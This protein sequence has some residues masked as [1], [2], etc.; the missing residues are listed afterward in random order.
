MK[1]DTLGGYPSVSAYV[2]AKLNRLETMERDF[3]S[4]FELMFSES[5]NVLYERSTGYRIVSTSYGEAR[6]AVLRCVPKLE[7]ALKG[8]PKGQCVGLA[9]ANGVEWIEVFWAILAAGYCPLLINTRLDD[10]TLEEVLERIGA[11]AVITDDRQFSVRLIKPEEILGEGVAGEPAK[12]FGTQIF[13]MSSGTSSRVKLCAYTAEQFLSLIRDSLDIIKKCRPIQTHYEGSL[14]LLAFLPFYHVFGLVAMYVWFGFFSRTFV[15]LQDLSPQTILGTI[16]RHKVT[17]VFAVPLFWET[18]YKECIRTIKERGN[19]TFA[20]FEKGLEIYRK[21]SGF[22]LLCG[23]FSKKAFREVRE[24]LFGESISFM[25][26]GGSEIKD[27][28]LEFFNAIG[29]PLAN[30]YGMTEIGI[31]SV[32]LSPKASVRTQ[33]FVGEP[34]SSVEYS[35]SEDGELLVRGPGLAS[36]VLDGEKKKENAG[37]WFC[38]GDLAENVNGHYRILGRKD[39]LI[40]ASSGE[41]LN[42]VL[43][44][45]RFDV[46]GVK[47]VCLIADASKEPVLL[48]SVGKYLR[49]ERIAELE[50]ALHS[51][52]VQLGL[53]GQVKKLVLVEDDLVTGQEF[54]LCRSRL[55]KDYA[56][57][58]LTEVRRDL[59]QVDSP[60][61]FRYERVRELFAIA[62][63]KQPE[64]IDPGTDFFMAGGNSLDY[65]ALVTQLREEFSVQFPEAEG[66]SL[67]TPMEMYQFI[68]G[69]D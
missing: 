51:R 15:H 25:I 47:Q 54:K 28:T 13:L 44:E 55:A 64:E 40:V 50:E 63:G 52:M 56:A 1:N 59:G 37:E 3:S 23:A 8:I 22:P 4:L 2:E 62:L 36:Y 19:E 21:L 20:R 18:V 29:Y 39:D 42:P 17:H 6:E 48:A 11:S 69:L 49:P 5:G 38:T 30:G 12:S 14:K 35:I 34:F 16:R 43:T 60:E 68:Q 10:E 58:R 61:D 9:M 7:R 53:N 67:V 41:N 31:T 66:E 33:G 24:N 65:L 32:E 26:T 46:P 57:G 45:A 27:Q